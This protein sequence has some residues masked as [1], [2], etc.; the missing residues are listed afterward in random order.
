MAKA[1]TFHQVIAGDRIRSL[2]RKTYGYDKSSDIVNA[3]SGLL[4]GRTVSLEGLPTIFPGDSLWL[5][6]E[7][8]QFSDRVT[9]NTDD[10][11]TIRLDGVLFTGWTTASIQRNINTVADSFTFSLPYDSNDDQLRELTKPYS[12]VPSINLT[13]SQSGF[14]SRYNS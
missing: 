5:P 2:A 11:I 13:Y 10:E 9:A 14:N 1:G 8:K 7:S 6:A 4:T 12:Y 3:N